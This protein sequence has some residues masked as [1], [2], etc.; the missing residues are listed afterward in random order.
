MFANLF[1]E[2][3]TA[4][5]D[6]PGFCPSSRKYL[7]WLLVACW[8]LL[9]AGPLPRIQYVCSC[10]SQGS[11]PGQEPV[12]CPRRLWPECGRSLLSPP[13]HIA[14]LS[15]LA[16]GGEFMGSNRLAGELHQILEPPPSLENT[17]VECCHSCISPEHRE[18]G[19][20]EQYL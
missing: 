11:P 6:V 5:R 3:I 17:T 2:G 8:L 12:H 16:R 4:H 7:L 1:V 15:S 10:P 18:E 14:A 19:R 13:R 9:G 20:S